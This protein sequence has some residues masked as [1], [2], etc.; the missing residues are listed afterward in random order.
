MKKKYNSDKN[1]YFYWH[2]KLFAICPKPHFH[3]L[4]LIFFSLSYL[5]SLSAL[6]E[7]I[8]VYAYT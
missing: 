7:P 6:D 4:S 5:H 1:S 8:V 3:L 2:Y